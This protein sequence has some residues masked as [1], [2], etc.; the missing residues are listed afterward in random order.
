MRPAALDGDMRWQVRQVFA[1]GT[2]REVEELLLA[3]VPIDLCIGSGGQ[4]PMHLAAANGRHQTCSLLAEHGAPVDE[5]DDRGLR[6]LAMAMPNHPAAALVLVMHGAQIDPEGLMARTL[7]VEACD[8]GESDAV[9]Y[10]L[11]LGVTAGAMNAHGR[12]ALQAAMA[13]GC[14]EIGRMLVAH[15]AR[16]DAMDGS[17]LT[18]LHNAA[19]ACS[20]DC[21]GWLVH[22]QGV[23]VNVQATPCRSTPLHNAA[24]ATSRPCEAAF[25]ELALAGGDLL[26]HNE[27][28]ASPVAMAGHSRRDR[29]VMMGL[30]L[31]PDFQ[32][33]LDDLRASPVLRTYPLRERVLACTRA[34]ALLEIG[35]EQAILA[36]LRH[37][38]HDPAELIA[39]GPQL[40]QALQALRQQAPPVD[41]ARM[42]ALGSMV[43]SFIARA[44][45]A[46]ALCEEPCRGPF[47]AAR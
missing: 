24:E 46:H 47:P 44:V 42:H 18:P 4:R 33:M 25:L 23:P 41:E 28:G 13:Q 43:S 5:P 10:L 32:A 14:L 11:A 45:A 27:F 35:D 20:L 1:H 38:A 6:P 19:L 37:W 31:A 21:I 29:C 7:L 30:A 8:R 12:G 26:V 36:V 39:L 16:P 3:G 40:P 17:G 15:G 22:E 9:R 2:R 34:Q